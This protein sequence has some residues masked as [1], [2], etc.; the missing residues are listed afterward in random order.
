MVL[1]RSTYGIL[2]AGCAAL[3]TASACGDAAL[4]PF[5]GG[6]NA[7][8]GGSGNT[9][10]AGG[11]AGATERA[12][13]GVDGSWERADTEV[14]GSWGRADAGVDGSYR[15]CPD[16]SGPRLLAQTLSGAPT[17]ARVNITG[18]CTLIAL[19][20]P[21][22]E[23]PCSGVGILGGVGTSCVLTFT[24][25]DGLSTSTTVAIVPDGPPYQCRRDLDSAVETAVDSHFEPASIVVD[26]S[27]PPADSGAD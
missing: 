24:S 19:C 10:G 5:D 14:D 23:T 15:Q 22:V 8:H 18:G 25:V 4:Q 13:A 21:T 16:V 11:A 1:M 20:Y 27:A 9:T 7:G 26:F 2:I 3:S 17:I 12:D 6:S